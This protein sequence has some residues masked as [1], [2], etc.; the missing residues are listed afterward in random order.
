M[1]QLNELIG[2]QNM[3]YLLNNF[4]VKNNINNTFNNKYI[5]I[6]FFYIK[7]KIFVLQD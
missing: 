3:N 7:L 6:Y 5:F 1:E 2:D 4:D